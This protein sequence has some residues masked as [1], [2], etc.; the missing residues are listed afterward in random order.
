MLPSL[1]FNSVNTHLKI[2]RLP[3]PQKETRTYS[4]WVFPK[5]G[6]KPP[7]WMVYNGSKPYF[8]MD[9]LGGN[10]PIFG[11]IQV[12]IQAFRCK[13]AG[14]V[15]G[16]R[17]STLPKR[18]VAGRSHNSPPGKLPLPVGSQKHHCR[19]ASQETTFFF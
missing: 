13:L 6:G 5:I 15:S 16:S 2:G 11:N 14:F 4:K 7:K 9:D 17:V 3:R 8:L 18:L 1:L 19:K 12:Y 10:T